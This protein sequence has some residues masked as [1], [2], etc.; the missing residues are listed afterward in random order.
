[1]NA[2][3]K[4]REEPEKEP[5]HTQYAP[6]RAVSVFASPT[7]TTPRLIFLFTTPQPPQAGETPLHRTLRREAAAYADGGGPLGDS[8]GEMA[9]AVALLGAGADPAVRALRLFGFK[10]IVGLQFSTEIRAI[11]GAMIHARLTCGACV[12]IFLCR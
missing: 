4:A 1:M 2:Q 11:A 10:R 5:E 3:N 7:L 6:A 8:P 12:R 9:L